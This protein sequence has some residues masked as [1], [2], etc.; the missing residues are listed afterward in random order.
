MAQVATNVSAQIDWLIERLRLHIAEA[1]EAEREWHALGDLERLEYIHEW[2]L[3]LSHLEVLND[4][5]SAWSPTLNQQQGYRWLT[6]ELERLQPFL[7]RVLR[8]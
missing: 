6:L 5:L 7:N 4:Y 3:T 2:P 8:A 1:N